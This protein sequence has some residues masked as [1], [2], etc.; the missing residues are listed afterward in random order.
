MASRSFACCT[1]RAISM[2]SLMLNMD[3]TALHIITRAAGPEDSAEIRALHARAF[4][5]GRFART[6]YRLR[7]GIAM[8][9]PYCRVCRIDGRLAAAVRF[10][11]ILIGGR[12]DALLLGLLA[13][14]PA[15]ANQGHGR[16]LVG[17][18]LEKAR[19]AGIAL[20]LLVGDEPYY[21]R[22]GF[23]P[24]PR[25]R[26]KLPGPVNPARLLAVELVPDALARFSGLVEADR[27]PEA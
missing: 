4:G 3:T 25:G 24:V 26:I 15:F 12:G 16:G 22:L 10:T 23:K 9:S 11:P 19:A 13:V 8:F 1:A 27:R 5:P 6:A 18:A 2:P 14:E 17:E 7:E 21:G 20:V